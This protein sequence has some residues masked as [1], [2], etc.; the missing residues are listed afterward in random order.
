MKS[1]S[2][3]GSSP[4]SKLSGQILCKTAPMLAK[5]FNDIKGAKFIYTVIS[6]TKQRLINP[7]LHR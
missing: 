3:L 2:H 5:T 1:M 4:E 6:F 7:V